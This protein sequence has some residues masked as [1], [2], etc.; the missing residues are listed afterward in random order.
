[1]SKLS[2]ETKA[3]LLVLGLAPGEKV[4][5]EIPYNPNK[6]VSISQG[7]AHQA[8][9]EH[10]ERMLAQQL[11]NLDQDRGIMVTGWTEHPLVHHKVVGYTQKEKNLALV[12]AP[13]RIKPDT[14]GTVSWAPGLQRPSLI[15]SN[16]PVTREEDHY[17]FRHDGEGADSLVLEYQFHTTQRLEPRKID[18]ALQ[19]TLKTEIYNWNRREWED[20]SGLVPMK[21]KNAVSY[22]VSQQSTLASSNS[23]S[24]YRGTTCLSGRKG[25]PMIRTEKLSKKYRKVEALK[26]LNLHVQKGSVFGLSVPTGRGSQQRC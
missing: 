5:V 6:G 15:W 23:R 14:D 17:F 1:M 10:R 9:N 11:N 16:A 2:L 18:I 8:L 19:N 26:N 20:A 4:K 25:D 22:F 13:V 12:H 7:V 24:R 3:I 21:G